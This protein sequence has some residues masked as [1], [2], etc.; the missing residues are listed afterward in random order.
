[1]KT[2]VGLWYPSCCF[3]GAAFSKT[4][5]FLASRFLEAK[6]V[7]MTVDVHFDD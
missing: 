1:M 7:I 3:N 4:C 2:S 5:V 6:D